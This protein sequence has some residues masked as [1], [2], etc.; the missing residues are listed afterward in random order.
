VFREEDYLQLIP[1]TKCEV[2]NGH[3]Q[4][5]IT[6]PAG[7]LYAFEA[8]MMASETDC[9]YWGRRIKLVKH[10]GVGDLYLLT[11]QSNMAGYGRDAGYDPPCLGVHLYSNN[12]T[13]ELASHP[14]NDST[15]TIYPENKEDASGTSPA[16]S[17]AKTLKEKLNIPIGLVQ[18]SLGGSK[19]QQWHPEEDG[20]LYRGMLK[21]LP[22]VG[23]IKGVLWYQGCSDAIK[24]LAPGYYDRFKN[25]VRLWREQLGQVP[26]ITVQLNR[27]SQN[28][29]ASLEIDR[30]W[31]MV[32]DA[33]RRIGDDVPN[34]FVVP[35][36]DI[37]MSDG[38]HNSS[39]G[40]TLLGYRMALVALKGIYGMTGL[41]APS[42]RGA[43]YVDDTHVHAYFDECYKI[44]GMDCNADGIHIEDATGLIPC[45]SAV[46]SYGVLMIE[47]QRPFTLPAKIHG[48]WNCGIP[49]LLAR[50]YT[51]LPILSFYGVEI[52]ENT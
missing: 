25:M 31:G 40:N 27:W 30:C 49:S 17:F 14:L 15:E 20:M 8:K 24:E 42:I 47:T 33:Q 45:K 3:W 44:Y 51:G 6:L 11:G 12:G 41:S 26:F 38:I 4:V 32:R 21:R 22:I 34:V 13:W 5:N 10:F 28:G 19:L 37:P 46:G 36:V 23:K 9:P 52:K 1:Y 43:E 29:P 16:L 7:G 50:D 18:A 48:Y 2:S 35:S 39:G